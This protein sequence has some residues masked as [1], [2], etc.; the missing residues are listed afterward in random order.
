MK[1]YSLIL[2]LAVAA[3]PLAGSSLAV[4]I[5]FD[6]TAAGLPGAAF[7]FDALQGVEVSRIDNTFDMMGGLTFVENGFL[8][9]TGATLGGVAVAPGL[10]A[11]YTLYFSFTNVTGGTAAINLP[12][13]IDG[14]SLTLFGVAGASSF[15]FTGA[16]VAVVNNGGNTPVVL[17]SSA[18][19]GGLIGAN[20]VSPNP[21]A[22][23]LF[24][25]INAAVQ[26]IVPGFI[27]APGGPLAFTIDAQHDSSTVQILDGGAVFLVRG[28]PDVIT[29]APVPE[30]S[31]LALLG[32]GGATLAACG[33]GRSAL[34]TRRRRAEGRRPASS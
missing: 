16:G 2:T 21:L 27:T 17:F 32:I 22:L 10:N 12:G 26:P 7:T 24:A 15:G 18:G 23:D 29:F 9:V 6:P 30:P 1:T 13:V 14:G 19:A 5:T 20:V 31:S 28:G 25:T 8:Q 4:P 11:D 33:I 34:A 3:G